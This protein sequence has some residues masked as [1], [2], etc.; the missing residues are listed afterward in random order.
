MPPALTVLL[1]LGWTVLTPAWFWTLAVVSIILAPPLIASILEV[2][3]KPEDVLLRQHLPAA[4]RA[5]RLHFSQALFALACLPYE[6][7]IGS[8][9]DR[10][11]D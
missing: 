7:F 1:V 6:A 8:R 5:A 11:H 10:A 9:C 3:Q 2:F 4:F